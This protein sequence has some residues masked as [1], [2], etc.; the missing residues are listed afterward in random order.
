M[1]GKFISRSE[2]PLIE[3]LVKTG[4]ASKSFGEFAESLE[5]MHAYAFPSRGQ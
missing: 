4:G 5:V 2:V 3:F 1:Q